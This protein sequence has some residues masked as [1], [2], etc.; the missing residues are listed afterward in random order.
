M[1]LVFEKK[2]P[3]L[4]KEHFFEAYKKAKNEIHIELNGT[5]S[6]HNRFLYFQR[7]FELFG[8]TL[9]PDVLDDVTEL[10]W[11]ET[12]RNIRLYSGVKKEPRDIKGK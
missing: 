6:M 7:L 4:E 12:Y 1:L 8:L 10:Y 9:D 5:A 3:L 2:F 11:N